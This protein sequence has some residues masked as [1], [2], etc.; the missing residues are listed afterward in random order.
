MFSL[1]STTLGCQW[2]G[3]LEARGGT[4]EA[5]PTPELKP[6]ELTLAPPLRTPPHILNDPKLQAAMSR[7]IHPQASIVSLEDLSESSQDDFLKSSS[8]GLPGAV[9]ADFNG[10]GTL[11]CAVLVRFPQRQ[12]V[13]EWLVVFQ[14]NADGDFKLRLLE[15]YD[16]FHDSIYLVSE[17]PGEL[18]VANSTR[19]HQ[20]RSPGITR[21]HPARRA[22]VFYWQKGRFQRLL[23]LMV[24]S[25]AARVPSAP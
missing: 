18:K 14:G 8:D 15:K 6:R 21:I 12:R 5:A 22:T 23:K 13:G 1:L 2:S 17:P 19:P 4:S 10:D 20:L 25:V 16:S 7:H 24:P 9:V 3:P 11:D